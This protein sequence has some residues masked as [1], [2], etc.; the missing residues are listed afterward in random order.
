MHINFYSASQKFCTP[1]RF[2]KNFPQRLRILNVLPLNKGHLGG[3]KS[4]YTTPV[5][6]ICAPM[7]VYT[8]KGILIC[9]SVFAGCI[10]VPNRETKNDTQ[11]KERATL[12]TKFAWRRY[13]KLVSIS[14]KMMTVSGHTLVCKVCFF[15]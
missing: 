4:I 15:K 8:L 11:P 2:M 10:C 6:P 5:P 1:L 12:H 9:S 3:Y 13:T 14:E 7:R